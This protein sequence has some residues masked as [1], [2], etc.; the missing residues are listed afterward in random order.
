[1]TDESDPSVL[2]PVSVTQLGANA[3]AVIR[4][5]RAGHAL[6]VSRN[7]VVVAMLKPITAAEAVDAGFDLTDRSHSIG[8]RDLGRGNPSA[9]V[10]RAARGEPVL[11]TMHNVPVAALFPV[12]DWDAQLTEP[13][14]LGGAVPA[15]SLSA[16]E[17]AAT[18]GLPA[19]DFPPHDTQVVVAPR[20]EVAEDIV[21]SEA[22]RENLRV[23]LVYAVKLSRESAHA[24]DLLPSDLTVGDTVMYS[25]Y[26]GHE[27][28]IDGEELLILM[29]RD[30]LV[31]IRAHSPFE[32]SRQPTEQSSER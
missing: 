15:N 22:G 31:T 1:M 18:D 32:L 20:S 26:G 23:G 28:T 3:A 21:I 6:P 2:G 24:D 10:D 4:M 19:R 14:D 8:A 12:G 5:V 27:I 29:S 9:A 30:I 7:G 13:E 17:L 25:K 16:A 11:V